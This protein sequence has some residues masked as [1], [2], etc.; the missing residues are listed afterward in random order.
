LDY[1]AR[2]TK[3]AD[4]LGNEFPLLASLRKPSIVYR[5]SNE[6]AKR[7]C[8]GPVLVRLH[9]FVLNSFVTI[10]GGVKW[11]VGP[12]RIERQDSP[13]LGRRL[14]ARGAD[15]GQLWRECAAPGAT[16]LGPGP[17][18]AHKKVCRSKHRSNF[19]F[20]TVRPT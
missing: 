15:G 4:S 2:D 9:F 19:W 13:L 7:F 11:A 12:P 3:A 1:R 10:R 5:S 20:R 14:D 18:G 8:S 16:R 17:K 6:F